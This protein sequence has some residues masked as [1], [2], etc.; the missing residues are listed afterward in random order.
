M[1]LSTSRNR[2]CHN[3]RVQSTIPT[4]IFKVG[5]GKRSFQCVPMCSRDVLS[6]CFKDLASYMWTSK[7]FNASKMC[8]LHHL[9]TQFQ[10]LQHLVS[11][12]LTLTARRTR[13]RC[14]QYRC[15]PSRA[16]TNYFALFYGTKDGASFHSDGRQDL[17]LVFD[18]VDLD[19]RLPDRCIL[20]KFSDHNTDPH[21]LFHP[22]LHNP[23]QASSSTHETSA[24]PI[25][26][27]ILT[28]P[29]N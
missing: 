5:T 16:K 24:T 25:K 27:N 22:G 12:L 7:V 9:A 3:G 2:I 11:M 14:Q 15:L 1:S 29:I 17:D 6:A 28:W 18:I 4:T 21:L 26:S 13:L 8:I 19:S 10:A 20:E 23:N